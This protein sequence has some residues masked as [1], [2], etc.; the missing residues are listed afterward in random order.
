MAEI[1]VLYLYLGAIRLCMCRGRDSFNCSKPSGCGCWNWIYVPSFGP[2]GNP[3]PPVAQFGDHLELTAPAEA[4]G[5]YG[6]DGLC[7]NPFRLHHFLDLEAFLTSTRAFV[8]I[9]IITVCTTCGRPWRPS[10]DW[11][12]PEYSSNL[13][14]YGHAHATPLL[15]EL[16]CL[17]GS[18]QVNSLCWLLHKRIS[19]H[20]DFSRSFCPCI[21][22]KQICHVLSH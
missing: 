17:L 3:F 21:V 20:R 4:G 9:W 2:N 19:L 5:S 12:N 8:F 7:R 18:F 10:K 14:N 16:Y 15:C 13:S 22:I 1:K 11:T 6:Q